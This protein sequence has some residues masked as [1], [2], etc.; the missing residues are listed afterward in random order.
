MNW[1]EEK[2]C[3]LIRTKAGRQAGTQTQICSL[4]GQTAIVSRALG[5]RVLGDCLATMRTDNQLLLIR[6]K[7]CHFTSALGHQGCRMSTPEAHAIDAQLFR[8]GG[9]GDYLTPRAH[10]K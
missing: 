5:P 4:A 3:I 6:N 8:I 1:M 7:L 2:V 10:A 9:G